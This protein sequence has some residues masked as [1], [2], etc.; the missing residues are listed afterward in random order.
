MIGGAL[1]LK[2]RL[3]TL[4]DA[5]PKLEFWNQFTIMERL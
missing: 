3:G 5:V 4:N 2:R 1:V